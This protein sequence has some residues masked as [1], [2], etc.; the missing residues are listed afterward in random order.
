MVAASDTGAW[1][2]YSFAGREATLSYH[3]LIEEFLGDMCTR[4]DRA[5]TATPS[6]ASPATSASRPASA[7]RRSAPARQAPAAVRFRISKISTVKVRLYDRRG[8]AF[9]REMTLPYGT[10]QVGWTPPSRGRYRLRIEAQGPSGPV[11]VKARTFRVVLPKPKPKK[12]P[13]RLTSPRQRAAAPTG[14]SRGRGSAR[15]PSAAPRR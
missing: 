6:G 4:T 8:L 9:S 5:S 1:S 10:H 11:G 2:L 14:A 15:R 7:S 13:K 12:R 3:Q